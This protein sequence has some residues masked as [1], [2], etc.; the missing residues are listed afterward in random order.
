[1]IA[2]EVTCFAILSAVPIAAGAGAGPNC[3]TLK[4]LDFANGFGARPA[5][6][7]S[8]EFATSLRR[9][10]CNIAKNVRK[11]RS[12]NWEARTYPEIMIILEAGK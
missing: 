8:V 6:S 7:S 4:T 10:L 5:A 11:F 9:I 3:P 1:M 12:R 2:C